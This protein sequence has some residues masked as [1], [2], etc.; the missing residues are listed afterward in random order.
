MAEKK[1]SLST[2]II[3]DGIRAVEI[4][5]PRASG[6]TVNRADRLQPLP[7][8]GHPRHDD[9]AWAAI[10]PRT[11]PRQ[12]DAPPIIMITANEGRH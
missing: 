3:S 1:P 10:R 7:R 11:L 12:E 5:F 2:T 9:A 8:S 6:L 4:A